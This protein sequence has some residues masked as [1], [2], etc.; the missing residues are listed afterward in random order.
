M[1]RARIEPRSSKHAVCA[2]AGEPLSK[3]FNTFTRCFQR[4]TPCLSLK[5]G[6]HLKKRRRRKK[7][8]FLFFRE[9]FLLWTHHPGKSVSWVMSLSQARIYI[10]WSI[11]Q[12]HRKGKPLSFSTG[13]WLCLINCDCNKQLDKRKW[14]T[15]VWHCRSLYSFRWTLLHS[16]SRSAFN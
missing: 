6:G 13:F 9:C 11:K 5:T 1:T 16:L 15:H 14:G 7:K 12:G 4:H 10:S 3:M 2:L 8:P